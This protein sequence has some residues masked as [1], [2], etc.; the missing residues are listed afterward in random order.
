MPAAS[1]CGECG[2]GVL[3]H[4]EECDDADIS[5]AAGEHCSAE[6]GAVRC[7]SPIHPN[8]K[9]PTAS[10]ALFALNA[11]VGHTNCD[12]RV[13]DVNGDAILAAS[14]ALLILNKAVGAAVTLACPA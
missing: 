5:Y 2:N 8:G 13:C 14:D 7:G 4:G 10:D 6:C 3:D 12:L 9:I 11:A 1:A